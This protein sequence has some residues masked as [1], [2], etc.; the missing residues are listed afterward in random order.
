[1]KKGL[2]W[3]LLSI[4]VVGIHKSAEEQNVT[5]ANFAYFPVRR[6]LKS[7]ANCTH[8]QI[9]TFEK[10]TV[11]KILCVTPSWVTGTEKISEVNLGTTGY[12]VLTKF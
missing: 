3:F 8:V 5:S 2:H 6:F 9:L 7:I 12:R 10:L 11:H 1:M 4:L